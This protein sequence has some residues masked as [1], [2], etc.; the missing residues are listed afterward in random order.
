ME[1]IGKKSKRMG[2]ESC[3]LT[4]TARA[5]WNLPP[6]QLIEMA[7]QRGEGQLT[8]TGA[9]MCDTGKFTGRSPKDRFIVKDALTADTVDWNAI[10]QPFEADQFEVLRREMG[11][12][13]QSQEVFVRDVYAGADPAY[14]LKVRI[15]NRNAYHNLFCHT[16]FLRPSEEELENF[17][18]DYHVIHVPEFEAN[19]ALDGTRQANFAILNLTQKMI[20][21]GGTGYAGEIKKGI[22]SLL[23]FLLPHQHHVLSMHCAANV[24]TQEGDTAIFFGL[25]GTGKT[26]LS[27]DPQRR[28]IG[29][30]EH[31]WSE[32]GVF[33][34]EG[35]CYAKTI[36]LT[37]ER[38][39][40]IFRA[41]RF[42]AILENTRFFPGTRTVDYTNVVVTPN[43]RTAYPINHIE[44]VLLP[45]RSGHPRHIFFLVADAFGVL[46]PVARLNPAQAMYHFMSGYT[47]KVAGTEQGINEPQATFSTCFGAAFMPLPAAQYARL[48]GEKMEAH[49]TQV[50]LINTGWTG[51]PYGVGTRMKL[52]HTRACITAVLNGNLNEVPFSVHPVFGLQVPDACPGVP[53]ALLNPRN[54]WDDP[55]AYDLQ[56]ER[57]AEKFIRNFE[58]YEADERI[59]AGAPRVVSPS[60]ED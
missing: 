7:L 20:L 22:F 21:V 18:P 15:I 16:M 54:T 48:L 19:P 25:S 4:H 23:N 17:E 14:R 9:L 2:L 32:N 38:E 44:N 11:A 50:W 33:N 5:Y 3:G 27:A 24:G 46:P 30:D 47:A 34:F 58:Q 59:L 41:I 42:G 6:A 56:A 29:D 8:S 40:D 37:E 43:T 31:G 51:G 52:P 35:G 36:D 57:L 55:A 26:T 1:E 28:L 53:T 39:P 45:S 49:H 10:N 60:Y 12:Y 13:L